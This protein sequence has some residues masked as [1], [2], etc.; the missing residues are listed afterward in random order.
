[1]AA[2]RQTK[3]ERWAE[4]PSLGRVDVPRPCEPDHLHALEGRRCLPPMAH[5]QIGDVVAERGKLQPKVAHPPLGPAD[6]LREEVVVDEADPHY[7]CV[8][9]LR[10]SMTSGSVKVSSS[11]RDRIVKSP[12]KNEPKIA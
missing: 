5:R 12:M 9:C 10:L 8:A 1:M 6:R 4:G 2:D 11:R 3:S 7:A